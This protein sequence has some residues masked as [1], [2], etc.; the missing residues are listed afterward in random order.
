MLKIVQAAVPFRLLS[1]P[2]VALFLAA[3]TFG[4]KTVDETPAG[5]A[6]AEE[7]LT[8]VATVTAVDHENRLVTLKDAEGDVLTVKVGDEVRN[9]PQVEVGDR[10]KVKYKAGIVASLKKP[11]DP[12]AAPSA[13]I[14]LTSAKMG[15]KPAAAIGGRVAL[16]IT[17][18]SVDTD[19]NILVFKGNDGSLHAIDVKKPEFQEYIKKL[20]PGDL[21]ELVLTETVALG[22]EKTPSNAP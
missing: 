12:T 8:A 14:G 1:L 9:L 15:E 2:A 6:S 17:V 13:A 10:L 4:C 7:V 19:H 11:G 3:S 21:V 5:T 18:E 20:R 16:T 22:F